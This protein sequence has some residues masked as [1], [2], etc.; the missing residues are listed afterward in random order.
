MRKILVAVVPLLLAS[1]I[2]AFV[3]FGGLSSSKV[4]LS[5]GAQNAYELLAAKCERG[6]TAACDQLKIVEVARGLEF[7]KAIAMIEKRSEN[8]AFFAA[9]CH[10]V[11]HIIGRIAYN[12]MGIHDVVDTM[13]GI[14]R[15]GVIHGAQE[16]WS[17]AKSLDDLTRE[18]RTLCSSLE[19][20]GGS[21]LD[22]CTHGIGH[23]FEHELGDWVGAGRLCEQNLEGWKAAACLSG[24]IMSFIDI[25]S[26][27]G[28]LAN[29]ENMLK[30]FDQC[31]SFSPE[32]V[33][34]CARSAGLAIMNGKKN[35][36]AASATLCM[37]GKTEALIG[38]CILGVGSENG[39]RNA[40]TPEN[41]ATTCLTLP[42]VAQD[43][44]L[45]GSALWIASNMMDVPAAEQICAARP[46]PLGRY[47]QEI[48]LQVQG[49]SESMRKLET[50]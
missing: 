31:D 3:M 22:T 12:E 26:E 39:Y 2:G 25:E 16:E 7:T 46:G 21:A 1:L 8:D 13:P 10:Q 35:D 14:C 50:R 27:A 37:A 18:A 23:S 5:K 24:A 48:M 20:I 38:D 9:E 36:L 17:D 30:I 43:P 11:A 6:N 15:A 33:V 32:G 4:S 40:A 41:A 19:A 45:A 44:C 29:D 47:C 42:T 34:E 28:R 49:V